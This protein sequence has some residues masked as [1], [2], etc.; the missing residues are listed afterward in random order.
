MVELHGIPEANLIFTI[1]LASGNVRQHT[2]DLS[3]LSVSEVSN[4]MGDGTFLASHVSEGIPI[5]V[6][7]QFPSAIYNMN[8]VELV[9]M[10]VEG[11]P[12][13][14]EALGENPLG[15]LGRDR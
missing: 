8:H 6:F 1:H 13:L 15:F 5:L 11:P 14:K 9:E 4:R 3:G 7:P 12:D 2:F 10:N